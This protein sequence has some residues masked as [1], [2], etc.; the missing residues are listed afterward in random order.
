MVLLAGSSTG[1]LPISQERL[2]ELVD[3]QEAVHSVISDYLP[4]KGKSLEESIHALPGLVPFRPNPDRKPLADYQFVN[5]HSMP[6]GD[7]R[8]SQSSSSDRSESGINPE[9]LAFA[10]GG[11]LIVRGVRTPQEFMASLRAIQARSGVRITVPPRRIIFGNLPNATTITDVLCLVYGGAVERAWSVVDGEV[12]VQFCD[13]VACRRYYEAN[14]NGIT[15]FGDHVIVIERPDDTD[16]LTAA[17]RERIHQGITR[18]IRIT[19]IANDSF[20]RLCDLAKGYE[21]DHIHL[22]E[23]DKPG[24]IYVFF[25]NLAH[26]W[27]FKAGIEEDTASW[28]DCVV[29]YLPDPCRVATGFHAN[30]IRTRFSAAAV[31]ADDV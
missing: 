18:V 8:R 29:D 15:V 10:P 9:A 2:K 23:C 7:H 30:A 24:M 26:A 21:I 22:V 14:S 3:A 20:S 11:G 12:I 16:Q 28:G 31:V 17:Q 4:K 1:W 5:E 19:G 13:D 25:R 6:N 27:D